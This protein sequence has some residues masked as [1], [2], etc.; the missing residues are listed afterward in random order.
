M[1]TKNSDLFYRHLEMDERALNE[2][3]RSVE[4]SFSSENPLQRWSF[5]E[6]LSHHAG[7]VNLGRISTLLMNHD[8]D[9]IVGP[10]RSKKIEN[11]RGV[12]V[13]GFDETDEGELRMKQVK[14]KSLKGVSISYLTHKFKKLA[15]DEEWTASDGRV[16]KGTSEDNPTYI[17]IKWSPIEISLTPIPADASVGV[18]RELTRQQIEQQIEIE[19]QKQTETEIEKQQQPETE[20][21]T[22]QQ[23]EKKQTEQ[24]TEQQIETGTRAPITGVEKEKGGVDMEK[25]LKEALDKRDQEHREGLKKLFDRAA[26]IGQEALVFRLIAEGKDEQAITDALFV[27]VGKQR[28]KSADAGEGQHGAAEPKLDGINDATFARGLTHPA[29]VTFE[30]GGN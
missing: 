21:E 6:V 9:R 17:A 15:P 12:A 4:L 24:E 20:T 28:G 2:E 3:E 27:E 14:S 11:G 18:G 30:E 8:P 1:K 7:H 29:Y 13:A 5:I 22:Q 23:P 16:I 10:V 19:Q 25:A 26:A